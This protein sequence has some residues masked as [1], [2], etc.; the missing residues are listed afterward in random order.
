MYYTSLNEKV[1][2]DEI[3]YDFKVK[4]LGKNFNVMFLVLC[5]LYSGREF[6]QRFGRLSLSLA[7]YHLLQPLRD[8]RAAL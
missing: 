6:V 7:G 4:Q 2:E 5:C 1:I 8:P 3:D